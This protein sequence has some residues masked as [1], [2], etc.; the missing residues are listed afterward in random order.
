MNQCPYFHFET[1]KCCGNYSDV[2]VDGEEYNECH[3]KH[4]IWTVLGKVKEVEKT[5]EDGSYICPFCNYPTT[6]VCNNP[7]C[8]AASHW[9]KES[10]EKFLAEQEKKRLENE[11]FQ[12]DFRTLYWGKNNREK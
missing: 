11:R 4:F 6:D 9:T 2:M 7:V 3:E 5:F 12:K 1:E 10:L 8:E